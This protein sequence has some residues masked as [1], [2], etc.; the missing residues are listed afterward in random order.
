M[1]GI[2]LDILLVDTHKMF[3]EGLKQIIDE[4]TDLK[5]KDEAEN[6][7]DILN[8]ISKNN[9]DVVVLDISMPS[10]NGI[11]IIK[12]IKEINPQ[13][14]I[15]ALSLEDQNAIRAMKAGASGYLTI[16]NDSSE[17]LTAIRKISLNGKYISQEMGE[18]LANMLNGKIPKHANLSDREYQIMCM[19][20]KGKTISDIAGELTLSVHTISTFRTRILKKMRMKNNSEITYYALKEGLVN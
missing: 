20:A 5:V 6:L 18:Q 19:I 3:R 9:Y 4:E 14:R 7:P 17:L 12:K 11:E 8:R 16:D 10:R 1:G 13:L 2:M 15:L